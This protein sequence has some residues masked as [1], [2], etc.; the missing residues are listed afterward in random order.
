LTRGARGT[1]PWMTF[2]DEVAR[3]VHAASIPLDREQPDAGWLLDLVG[4][5]SIVLIGEASHGTHEFYRIRAQL[6]RALIEEA[7]FSAVAV[8]ADWPDAFRVNR[9]VQGRGEDEVE[10]ALAT[11]RRFPAWMWRNTVVRDFA[12]WLREH[13]DGL[14]H[15]RRAGF[16]GMDL[17]SLYESI[18]AVLGHLDAVDPEAA[19]RARARYACL[20]EFAPDEQRYGYAVATGGVEP[21]EAAAVEQLVELRRRRLATPDGDDEAVF[22][23]EQNARLIANAER[24]YRMMF[25]GR[26]SSWNLRDRHMAETLEA[27]HG[28]L[29]RRDGAARIVVWAHNSHLG[30]ARATDMALREEISVGELVRERWR[31][32]AVSV[33]FTGYSGTVT[34]AEDWGEPARFMTVRPGLASSWE[35][36]MH[37]VGEACFAVRLDGATPHPGLRES[38]IERAI[39]VIY[40][41]ETERASHYFGARLADQF[42][43]VVHVDE[44]RALE[45]LEPGDLWRDAAGPAETFPSAL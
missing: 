44:S 6:T 32:D 43:A 13:N 30:D 34:A 41:P 39:G 24:Y 21:C 1:G 12:V 31:E 26:E 4:D 5:A 29:A 22:S 23:A 45:P 17:Y 18:E 11:F 36:L 20:E 38:R 33:G 42:D 35:D 8:E 7:G 25:R 15:D 28:H 27:L 19:R 9:F 37:R 10:S 40:R 16:Y 2:T 3:A 14:P